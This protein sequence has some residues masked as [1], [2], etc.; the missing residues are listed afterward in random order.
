MPHNFHRQAV[1]TRLSP[2]GVP[3]QNWSLGGAG[4]DK[5]VGL[6]IDR[7][8]R[9]VLTGFRNANVIDDEGSKDPSGRDL[10]VM[11]FTPNLVE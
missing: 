4:E 8:G 9:V 10:L 7:E 2:S 3:L 1:V 11:R 5:P 6:I